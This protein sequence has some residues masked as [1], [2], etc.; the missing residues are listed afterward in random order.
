[1]STMY[2]FLPLAKRFTGCSEINNE[3]K[4]VNLQTYIP[5]ISANGKCQPM[6]RSV[7]MLRKKSQGCR[8][9][10][11]DGQQFILDDWTI[12]DQSVK[13]GCECVFNKNSMYALFVPRN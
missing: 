13:V 8:L 2:L 7:K 6:Y 4:R 11:Q 9:L 10:I 3:M 5:F 12:Y 1:M